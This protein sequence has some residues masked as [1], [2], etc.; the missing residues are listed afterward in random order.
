VVGMKAKEVMEHFRQVGKWVNW[1]KTCDQFLHGNPDVEV[2]GIATAWSPTNTSLKRASDMGFN[3]FITHE[4]AFY[5]AYEGTASGD[6]L[7]NKKKSL[8][9]ELGISLMQCHDTWDRMPEV[10]IVDA[11]AAFLGFET[12]ARPV[13]SFY[14]V[15]LLGNISVEETANRILEKVRPLGQDTVLILGDKHKRVRR[16]VVGTGAITHLPS[17]YALDADLILATDDGIN[18]WDGGLWAVDLGIPLLIVNHATSEKPGVQAMARYLGKKF[19]E[20][21]VEYIDVESPYSI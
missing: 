6:L 21:G 14:K 19:P 17:M 8:L 2:K 1:D 15:C 13:Q 7:I 11:W 18:F 3:L 16:M 5:H 20:V 10:G 4:P 9:D 12:E